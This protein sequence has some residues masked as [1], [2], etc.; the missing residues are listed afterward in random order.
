MKLS[1]FKEPLINGLIA[2]FW[3]VLF[4][5][6]T[7]NKDITLALFIIVHQV[8]SAITYLRNRIN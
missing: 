7:G 5:I 2:F 4:F 1:N 6:L 3:A 8:H